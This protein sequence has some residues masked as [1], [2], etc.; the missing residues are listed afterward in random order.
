LP[1]PTVT[2]IAR[3]AWS[4]ITKDPGIKNPVR[5]RFW[6][7][8]SN[9]FSLVKKASRDSKTDEYILRIWKA[10]LINNEQVFVAELSVDR[11]FSWPLPPSAEVIINKAQEE[12][13]FDFSKEK[14]FK[15]FE[16]IE[17]PWNADPDEQKQF[18]KI[19]II[20]F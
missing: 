17:V 12:L 19:Y 20:S 3:Q 2:S 11:D 9:D 18:K 13:F 7:N 4:Y 5:P 8:E 6:S 14:S 10:R 16:R 15:G 1:Q